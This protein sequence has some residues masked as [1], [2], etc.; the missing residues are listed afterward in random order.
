MPVRRRRPL[1]QDGRA[2]K[3][4]LCYDRLKDG[5]EPACAKACPTDSIQF[6]PYE[7]LVDVAQRRVA[8]CRTVASAAPTSTAPATRPG[9]QLAGG[10]GPFFLLTEPPERY[11]L[12]AEADS[13]IQEN[14]V[15]ATLAAV[16]A[17]LIAAGGRSS[18]SLRHHVGAV[19]PA[20]RGPGEPGARL[21]G[22]LE[23]AGE[24]AELAP[25]HR[26]PDTARAR[27]AEW[28]ADHD[29]ETRDSQPA[30]G[31]RGGPGPVDGGRAGGAG[32]A[33]AP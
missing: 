26:P 25:E 21:E 28:V 16:S 24:P 8:R 27:A 23:K 19:E 9:A 33:R 10:L 6:G 11:G 18:R 13:P 5:L 12:P 15:P 4:T 7:E 20:D 3:C 22:P 32:R 14:V 1:T 29:T 2:S 30:L 31:A 17:G